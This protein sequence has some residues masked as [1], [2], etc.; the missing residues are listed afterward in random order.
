[1]LTMMPVVPPSPATP[2]RAL[3]NL[4]RSSIGDAEAVDL[5]EAAVDLGG[6]APGDVVVYVAVEQLDV[7]IPSTTASLPCV[8]H[9]AR[10]ERVGDDP[11]P[12][13]A[14]AAL[15][16]VDVVLERV[17]SRIWRRT[18]SISLHPYF[19]R[20]MSS[21]STLLSVLSATKTRR[22]ARQARHNGRLGGDLQV[23][24]RTW[25]GAVRLERTQGERRGLGTRSPR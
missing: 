17:V 24:G 23:R 4:L 8:D 2:A 10:L 12:A 11:E 7:S 15:L 21:H 5:V 14:G 18:E 1:M 20:G 16:R 6:V 19:L 13:L 25:L 22:P 9:R 3:S